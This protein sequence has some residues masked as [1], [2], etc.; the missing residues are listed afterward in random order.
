[1]VKGEEVKGE[2]VKREVNGSSR[3][4]FEFASL[5]QKSK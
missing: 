3:S 1:M 2:E 5:L 4:G